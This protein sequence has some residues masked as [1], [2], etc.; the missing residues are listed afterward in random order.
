MRKLKTIGVNIF[1]EKRKTR[2]HVGTLKRRDEELVFTYN[3]HYFKAKHVIP[4]GPEFPLTQKE[5]VAKQL[6]PSLEDRLPSLQ[7]P[8]YPEYCLAMGIDPKERDPLILL[9]TIGR[10]GPSSF[11][12]YPIFERTI[13]SDDVVKLR[14][15]LGLTTREFAAIF[16]FS[17]SS[18]TALERHRILG[19]EILKRLEIILNYPQ[20]ALDLL[21][22]NGGSVIHEK[23]IKA[24]HQLKTLDH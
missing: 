22:I 8:A 15:S 21:L 13:T 9:S 24:T 19:S 16:E 23:W 3:T 10:K 11:I 6:F 17:Q 1:L 18:I 14:E 2:L 5:F 20:V 7:N 12:F 4:L